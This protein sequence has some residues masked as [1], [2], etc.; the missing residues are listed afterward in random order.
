MYFGSVIESNKHKTNCSLFTYKLSA[1]GS[2]NNFHLALRYACGA[3]R[4][5][6]RSI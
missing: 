4:N 6:Q 1:P 5:N 2:V 3:W